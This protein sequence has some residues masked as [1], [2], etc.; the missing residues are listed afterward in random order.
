MSGFM[1]HQ[2]PRTFQKCAANKWRNGSIYIPSVIHSSPTL[3]GTPQTNSK[4]EFE[5]KR[6]LTLQ[7]S[8]NMRSQRGTQD[9]GEGEGGAGGA[10]ISQLSSSRQVIGTLPFWLPRSPISQSESMP[11]TL[12]T[13]ITW[14][15][16]RKRKKAGWEHWS[17]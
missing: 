4:R 10:C 5:R 12:L 14:R 17:A 2:T 11:E 16:R 9:G 13:V 15:D 3:S 6:G 7:H 1:R 8:I